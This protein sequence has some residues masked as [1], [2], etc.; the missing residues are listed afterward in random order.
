MT[1]LRVLAFSGSAR[2]GSFNRILLRAAAAAAEARGA[3]A[4]VLELAELG[5]PS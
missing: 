5:L 4:T 1:A 2:R 3:R